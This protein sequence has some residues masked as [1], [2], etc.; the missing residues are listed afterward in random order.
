M[1]PANKCL[2]TRFDLLCKNFSRQH[3]TNTP[4][5]SPKFLTEPLTLQMVQPLLTSAMLL[6]YFRMPLSRKK[7]L[8][9]EKNGDEWRKGG[10]CATSLTVGLRRCSSFLRVTSLSVESLSSSFFT[11]PDSLPAHWPDISSDRSILNVCRTINQS[12]RWLMHRSGDHPDIWAA[13]LHWKLFRPHIDRWGPAC[14]SSAGAGG[15]A[16]S[17][18]LIDRRGTSADF[19]TPRNLEVEDAKE[20]SGLFVLSEIRS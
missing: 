12:D 1:R 9:R 19:R 13:T 14:D 15:E 7:Y 20:T 5:H 4:A 6:P 11:R 3:N 10:F 2:K 8:W 16:H 18:R 17:I